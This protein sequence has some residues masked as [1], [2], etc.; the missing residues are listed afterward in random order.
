MQPE[1]IPVR[2]HER[3]FIIKLE[4]LQERQCLQCN[5]INFLTEAFQQTYGVLE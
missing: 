2:N 1:I 3:D 5:M 4:L